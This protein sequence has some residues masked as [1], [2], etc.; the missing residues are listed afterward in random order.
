MTFLVLLVCI[1]TTKLYDQIEALDEEFDDAENKTEI[2]DKIEVL[3]EKIAKI[4]RTALYGF[5]GLLVVGTIVIT[6][7]V[8]GWSFFDLIFS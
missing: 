3:E 7:A 2:E 8:R 5:S 6:V 4:D 1:W